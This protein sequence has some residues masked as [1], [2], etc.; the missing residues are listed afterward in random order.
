MLLIMISHEILELTVSLVAA[1]K[2]ASIHGF[3]RMA[4]ITFLLNI[5]RSNFDVFY[6]VELV[7]I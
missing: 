1:L 5:M 4:A 3:R 6:C 7:G 2:E